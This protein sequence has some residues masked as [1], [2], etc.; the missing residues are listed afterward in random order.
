MTPLVLGVL[1]VVLAGPVPALLARA[2][3]LRRTPYAALLAWQ[4][5][6]LAAVLAAFGSTL[7]LVTEHV[8]V[9]DGSGRMPGAAE[10]AVAAVALGVTGLVAGRLL[11]SAHRVGA[12]LRRIRRRHADQVDLLGRVQ[13]DGVRVLDDDAPVAYCLPG[14]HRS[15]VVVSAGFIERLDVDEVGAV[16]A[17]EW[18]HLRFRH[19]L[20][21]EFF[22][23]LHRAFPRWVSSA[24]ALAEVRLLVEMCADRAAARAAGRRPLAQALV[25]LAES[26]A[27]AAAMGAGSGPTSDLVARIEVLGDP[28]PPRTQGPALVVLALAVLVLPTWLVVAPWLAAVA[29]AGL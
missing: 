25:Q 16:L 9:E 19:D 14:I 6:A 21:V 24:R 20:V 28:A 2:H 29:D 11:L 27:P 4:A 3:V 5:V 10:Y 7:A 15:R 1:A 8:L 12:S 22:D 13:A 18:A 23:V 17:H 26:R